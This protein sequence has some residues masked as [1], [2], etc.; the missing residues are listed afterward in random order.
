MKVVI[1]AGGFGTRLCEKTSEIPKPLI[2]VG[3]K[4]ILWH[5]MKRFSLYGYNEFVVA[6]G[7]FGDKVKQNFLKTLKLGNDLYVDFES[8][9]SS[10]IQTKET[11]WKIHFVDTGVHTQTGGRLKKVSAYLGNERFMLAYGD[12]VGDVDFS[13]LNKF[14]SEHGKLATL[15]CA[16]PYGRYGELKLDGDQVLEF[17]EKPQKE[18]VSCGFFVLEPEVL[19]LIESEE[20]VWEKFPLVNLATSREL[21][22]YK[23]EGFWQPMDTLKDQKKLENLWNNNQ[24]SWLKLQKENVRVYE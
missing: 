12:V 23:H 13:S 3:D 11:P 16:Q 21:M 19:Q 1:L 2:E 20:T 10:S 5:I 14:H 9:T 8:N 17:R 24:A 7:K 4:P 22:A 15:T 6:L 18:W